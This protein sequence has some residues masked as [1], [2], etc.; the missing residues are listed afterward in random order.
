MKMPEHVYDI[1]TINDARIGDNEF[2]SQEQ[3]LCQT[4]M[5]KQYLDWLHVWYAGLVAA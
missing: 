2:T 4:M 3:R 5:T 1:L